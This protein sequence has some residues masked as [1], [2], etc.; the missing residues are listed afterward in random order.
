MDKPVTYRYQDS[1]LMVAPTFIYEVDLYYI[2]KNRANLLSSRTYTSDRELNVNEV[3]I[4]KRFKKFSIE[5]FI[6]LVGAPIAFIKEN[7]L[8]IFEPIKP[9][10]KTTIKKKKS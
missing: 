2:A 7:N 9:K 8:P 6:T 3:E 4:V 1:Q 5:R 10:R